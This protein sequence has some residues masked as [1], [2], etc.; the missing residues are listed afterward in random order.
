[1]TMNQLRAMPDPTQV[2]KLITSTEWCGHQNWHCPVD[3]CNSS[4]T[5]LWR[6][7][8]HVNNFHIQ[9]VLGER[10]AIRAGMIAK[11][12]T[13]MDADGNPVQMSG[14]KVVSGGGE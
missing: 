9:A 13:I 7:E 1:M 2:L 6:T 8:A 12:V 3:E 14:G 11:S 4:S 10:M 5:D